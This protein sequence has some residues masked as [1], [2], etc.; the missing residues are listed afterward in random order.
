MDM[1]LL[2]VCVLTCH[3]CVPASYLNS[4]L[5]GSLVNNPF[6]SLYLSFKMNDKYIFVIVFLLLQKAISGI[7]EYQFKWELNQCIK[8]HALI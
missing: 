7:E 6:M 1:F 2:R 8:A 4:T 5:V 3:A